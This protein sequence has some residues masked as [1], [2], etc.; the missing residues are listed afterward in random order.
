MDHIKPMSNEFGIRGRMPK[1]RLGRYGPH[2]NDMLLETD[3]PSDVVG[4]ASLSAQM[5]TRMSGN[6]ARCG[7]TPYF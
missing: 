2:S 1:Y 3:R 6:I 5:M 4:N 7:Q